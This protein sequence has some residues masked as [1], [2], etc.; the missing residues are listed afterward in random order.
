MDVKTWAQLVKLYAKGGD[1]RAKGMLNALDLTLYLSLERDQRNIVDNST[2]RRLISLNMEDEIEEDDVSV[3]IKTQ[4][5]R[6]D[7][8]VNLV[9]KDTPTDGIRRLVRISQDIHKC[10]RV[11]TEKLHAFARTF[12]GLAKQYL[13]M[14]S[15]TDGERHSQNFAVLL[16]ENSKLPS[17]TFNNIV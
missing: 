6:V 12:Q 15:S 8:I 11:N 9:A 5:K 7:E 14:S 13:N 1:N 4:F 10:A 17:S 3:M 16:L 2:Q